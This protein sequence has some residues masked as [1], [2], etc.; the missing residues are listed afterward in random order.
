MNYIVG[1]FEILDAR[2]KLKVFFLL[3]LSIVN[4]LVQTLG[5]VS[6]MPFIAILSEPELV[7]T[8]QK[9]IL[10]KDFLGVTDYDSLLIVSGIFTFSSLILSHFFSTL[11]T[12]SNQLFFNNKE[13]HLTR[14]LLDIFLSKKST[15]FYKIK[16][17][18]IL[19]Y[20]LSDI[21]RVLIG[22][23]AAV[24]SLISD[25][26]ICA[27]V[28]SLLL[29]L[30]VWVT[31]TTTFVLTACY[32]LIYVVLATKINNYGAEFSNL[33]SRIYS[34]LNHAID[35]FRE[36]RISGHQNYFVDQYNE[37]S[38][39]MVTH[40]IRYYLL[41]L[42]PT[43]ILEILAFGLLIVV[44]T[45]F[46][47]YD[48][49]S[50]MNVISIISI[51]AFAT[52]RLV[53][54]LNA[55][56]GSI[57]KI[58]HSSSVLEELLSQFNNIDADPAQKNSTIR[59]GKCLDLKQSFGLQNTTFR[60]ECELPLVLDEYSISI[61][62]GQFICLSGKSG[63]GKSTVLDILLGLI[64]PDH[65]GLVVDG[66]KLQ[67]DDIR[68]W[69][70]NI[71]YV[72]QKIL[73]LNGT[74]SENIAFGIRPEDINHDLVIQAAKLAA[75]NE[76]IENQLTDGY[77]TVLGDGGA[78]L[79]GGEKQRIG[80]ARS[81]YHNPQILIFD[82]A[83]NELDQETELKILDSIKNLDNKTIIFVSHKPAVASAADEHM[84]INKIF[85]REKTTPKRKLSNI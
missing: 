40:S 33:E 84:V 5:I 66:Q 74:V 18:Q 7:E 80:I 24:M 52:Y 62:K 58:I 73:F 14:D 48:S 56:F 35:L 25:V 76:L 41:T 44:A 20:I 54:L 4:S 67:N 53:P 32:L 82:E 2:D 47:T 59:A 17:T 28:F 12:W 23:Q 43:Q 10:I 79:S 60:Y 37:P 63:A 3:V 22:T 26:L 65:G 38:K 30:D 46:A 50:S 36:I 72:P 55:I 77:D 69:Q 19:K 16:K 78:I 64:T 49:S 57:E 15:A 1:S 31:L 85:A 61:R 51:F 6:I 70:N 75:I 29:Y 9:I 11:T 45:Y 13:Y 21:E 8:N 34:A 42:L 81:L 71:G 68:Y 39:E 83:T 27:V